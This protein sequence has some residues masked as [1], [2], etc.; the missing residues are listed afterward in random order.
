MLQK[1]HTKI[2]S[3]CTLFAKWMP[4][5]NQDLILAD[6]SLVNTPAANHYLAL[7]LA[8]YPH[9]HPSANPA[10]NTSSSTTA[11][12]APQSSKPPPP[13]SQKNKQPP[14]SSTTSKRAHTHPTPN[15]P[16]P[17]PP[18]LLPPELTTHDP[19]KYPAIDDMLTRYENNFNHHLKIICDALDYYAATE[20]VA[21]GRLCALL[22]F[23][24]ER[25][26]GVG[27]RFVGGG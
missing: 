10:T 1:V 21:L 5:L 17:P 26:A 23:A 24:G 13:S 16:P 18:S 8:H 6:P 25:A 4:R 20:T 14:P 27:E 7:H 3:T 9:H 15:P 2:L 12:T 22:S 19:H 11:P